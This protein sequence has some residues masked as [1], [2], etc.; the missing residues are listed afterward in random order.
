MSYA[1]LRI[2]APVFLLAS[3]LAHAWLHRRASTF[4]R[5]PAG[6]PIGSRNGGHLRSIHY[7]PEGAQWLAWLRVAWVTTL[8]AFFLCAYEWLWRGAL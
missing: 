7:R 3:F 4:L 5:Y 1:M 6:G 8:L 2:L